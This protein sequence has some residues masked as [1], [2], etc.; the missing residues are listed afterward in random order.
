MTILLSLIHVIARY[1]ISLVPPKHIPFGNYNYYLFP[2]FTS[3]FLSIKLTHGLPLTQVVTYHTYTS[4]YKH[5][6]PCFSC[7]VYNSVLFKK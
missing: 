1:R 7:P 3:H 5:A 6:R 4:R 2:N